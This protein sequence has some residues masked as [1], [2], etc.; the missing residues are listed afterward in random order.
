[1]KQ[2]CLFQIHISFFTLMYP[3]MNA[4]PTTI[5]YISLKTPWLYMFCNAFI[6]KVQHLLHK[7]IKHIPLHINRLY[8]L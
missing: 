8:L 7:R 4:V 3:L 1:M 2:F 6:N 5:T